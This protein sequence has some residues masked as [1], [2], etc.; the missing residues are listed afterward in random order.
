MKQDIYTATEDNYITAK[1]CISF[2]LSATKIL[3]LTGRKIDAN[4]VLKQ[5]QL[6]KINLSTFDSDQ[7][8]WKG[9]QDLFK[10][11]VHDVERLT[12]TQK[13]QYLKVSLTGETA[14]VV[15]SIEISSEEYTLAKTCITV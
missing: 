8:T 15:A 2:F 4:S 1:S 11:L 14:A 7:L 10:L 12:S 13:F 3:D 6:S 9:F 5:V